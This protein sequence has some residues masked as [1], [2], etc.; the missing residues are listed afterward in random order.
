MVLSKTSFF[1]LLRRRIAT[2]ALGL[3][4]AAVALTGCSDA[5]RS[6]GLD[7]A[8]PD[9]FAVVSR[10]PLTLPPDMRQLPA[11]SPGAA[12]PQE[13]APSEVAAASMFGPGAQVSGVRTNAL[14]TG[15]GGGSAGEQALLAQAGADK[16]DPSIRAK[17]DQ[18]TTAMIVADRSWVDSLLFWQTY[19]PPYKVVDP[20]KET[21]RLRQAQAQG[22]PLND[23][24][25]PTIERKKKAPLEGLF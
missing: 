1:P 16:A 19:E 18:E 17:V 5:R 13:A 24:V 12:R 9:E 14:R 7:R 22:T 21:Q 11:P 20:A 8:S 3:A 10:A 25:V 15:P 2:P 23:G 6:L 4:V